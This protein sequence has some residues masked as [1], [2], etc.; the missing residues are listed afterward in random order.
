MELCELMTI[1]TAEA[2]G[3]QALIATINDETFAIPLSSILSIENIAVSEINSVDQEAVIY[4]RGRIIPLVYLNKLFNIESTRKDDDHITV[5][6]CMHNDAY[7]GFVVDGLDG[8]KEISNKSLGI[9]GDN[10][11]FTGASILEDKLA[12]ILNVGSFVA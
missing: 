11:F 5:V 3:D 9:L 10:D 8:Q 4:L 1:D 2:T 6:V 12:L 7:F